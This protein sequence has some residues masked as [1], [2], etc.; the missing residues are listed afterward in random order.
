MTARLE[1]LVADTA[2]LNPEIRQ[3]DAAEQPDVLARHVRDAAFR[4][5]SKQTDPSKRVELVNA[6]LGLLDQLDDS[7]SR[8]PE[9]LLSLRR[10]ASPGVIAMSTIRPAIP[11]SD[12]ALL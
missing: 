11:L 12:A 1:R 4:A 10:D 7:A 6:V 5:L 9:Q 3:V 8:H 2:H